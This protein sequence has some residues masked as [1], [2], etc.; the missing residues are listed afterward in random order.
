MTGSVRIGACVHTGT[1]SPRTRSD[2]LEHAAH[3]HRVS[4]AAITGSAANEGEDKWSDIDLAFGLADAADQP[5]IL[6]DWTSST[7]GLGVDVVPAS[8]QI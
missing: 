4:G 8:P 3:D 2:L 5:G 6:S 1:A 7:G